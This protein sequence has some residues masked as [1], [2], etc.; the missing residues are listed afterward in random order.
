MVDKHIGLKDAYSY[1]NDHFVSR[2]PYVKV[3]IRVDT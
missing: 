2:W 3:V 1:C